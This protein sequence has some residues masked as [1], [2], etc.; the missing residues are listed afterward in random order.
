[1]TYLNEAVMKKLLQNIFKMLREFYNMWAS[2]PLERMFSVSSNHLLE[3]LDAII[4][5]SIRHIH[6]KNHIKIFGSISVKHV[7]NIC[8][9]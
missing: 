5:S 7:Y 1:M 3:T 6:F 8:I 9:A 4:F 2:C